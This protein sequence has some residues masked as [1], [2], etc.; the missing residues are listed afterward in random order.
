GDLA[1]NHGINRE[2]AR[3]ALERAVAINREADGHLSVLVPL[4][5]LGDLHLDAG[6]WEIGSRYLEQAVSLAD[7]HQ[8]PH[9]RW[10]PC[11]RLAER[12]LLDGRPQDAYARLTSQL[13]DPHAGLVPHCL[14]PLLAWVQ[15]ELG[16]VSTAADEI[17]QAVSRIRN[18]DLA[19]DLPEALRI[20]ALI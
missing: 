11:L 12:D 6:E 4:C 5:M 9:Q 17:T 15:L 20:Q 2:Q 13:H 14:P 1:I 7:V 8:Q 3:A 19:Y 18:A 10:A 16:H